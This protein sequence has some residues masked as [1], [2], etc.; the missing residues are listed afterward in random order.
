M[1]GRS[2]IGSLGLFFFVLENPEQM[3]TDR[4]D[5]FL[6][7]QLQFRTAV[8]CVCV[9]AHMPACLQTLKLMAV[10]VLPMF[11]SMLLL[12]I[13]LLIR[14]QYHFQPFLWS[15]ALHIARECASALFYASL[16]LSSSLFLFLVLS[17]LQLPLLASV[18]KS[19][20]T[21]RSYF[22]ASPNNVLLWE[23]GCF[24]AHFWRVCVLTG[25]NMNRSKTL[26]SCR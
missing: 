11:V 6:C 12:I 14:P 18:C 4:E 26:L 16:V 23:V 1:T 25:Q 3:I 7:I 10:V 19:M 17:A 5:L 13:L 24:W 8:A 15:A 20:F 21:C 2:L 22:A 9:R